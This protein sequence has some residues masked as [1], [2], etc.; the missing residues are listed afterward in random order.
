MIIGGG[1]GIGLATSFLF[2]RQ[3]ASA[4]IINV[5]EWRGQQVAAEIAREGGDALAIKA[6]GSTPR[7]KEQMVSETVG[8][9]GRLDILC[10]NTGMSPYGL[11]HEMSVVERDRVLDISPQRRIPMPVKSRYQNS[12]SMAEWCLH[13]LLRRSRNHSSIATLLLRQARGDFA[14]QGNSYGLYAT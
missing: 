12:L 9:L 10:N 6:D 7:D 8:R 5:I 1:S 13:R 2:A 14:D 11:L 4:A 3:G